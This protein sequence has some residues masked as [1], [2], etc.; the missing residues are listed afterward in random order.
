MKINK[1]RPALICLSMI[2][3]FSVCSPSIHAIDP[4]PE[5]GK[6]ISPIIENAHTTLPLRSVG[7][8]LDIPWNND[9]GHTQAVH[10]NK[11]YLT[12]SADPGSTLESPKLRLN[13]MTTVPLIELNEFKKMLPA[14]DFNSNFKI[15]QD[16]LRDLDTKRIPPKKSVDLREYQT[17]IK[18]QYRRGTCTSF[19]M[20]AAIEARYKHIDNKK[21]RN[22][23]LSEQ[24]ANYIQKVLHLAEYPSRLPPGPKY[25]ENQIGRWGSS[26]S[27]YMAALLA[28]QAALP[29]E[30]LMPYI[31]DESYGNTNED[32][33]NP[34]LDWN[35][36]WMEQKTVDDFNFTE[37][38]FPL[39]ALNGATYGISSFNIIPY[40]E[41]KNLD[42][43]KNILSNGYE[44]VF[45]F[46]VTA[47]DPS[48]NDD[49]WDPG[50]GNKIGVHS[51][52]IVGYDDAKN[53]FI[54]KNS[55]GYDNSNKDGFTLYSY[56]WITKGHVF[57][58]IYITDVIREPNKYTR[59]EQRFLGRWYLD[60][61]GWK[62]ILDIYHIPGFFQKHFPV[63][64]DFGPEDNRIGTYFAHDG[65][66]Y[67]VNGKIDGKT[68]EFY[69]DFEGDPTNTS[70]SKM[71][72]QP[73]YGRIFSWNPTLMAGSTL[74]DSRPYGFYASKTGYF[75]G[76][77]RGGAVEPSDFIG[78][79]G[80]NHD[81]WEGCLDIFDI[82]SNN[83][84][85]AR[86]IDRN[87]KILPVKG[88][89]VGN[90]ELKMDISFD[91]NSPQPFKALMFSWEK[92]VISGSTIWRGSPF[93]WVAYRIG[94][95]PDPV[96]LFPGTEDPSP[97]IDPKIPKLPKIPTA[98]KVIR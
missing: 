65:K 38:D 35:N 93:P 20:V 8:T 22:I 13:N 40:S 7:S 98:D 24:Y 86:Y 50:D 37:T 33:D 42:Y 84:I 29:E 64:S 58:A 90:R 15:P 2:T 28:H 6:D 57:D 47:P 10:P 66:V 79:W 67:R 18:N 69:I 95:P 63:S 60:H 70:Y 82:D 80:M 21:Y 46:S 48:P 27:M 44:I 55:W 75:S 39:S 72:G 3:A 83:N 77:G 1:I 34:K 53:C 30:K 56:D 23:D 68:I 16:L 87:G 32:R 25:R 49:I 31:G 54:V 41:L 43:Y 26:N 51:M 9:L 89:I 97:W 73:F 52:L 62:G 17:P 19:A 36:K 61:D 94:P 59:P 92:G 14:K 45:D 81:G 76:D 11:N 12:I 78:S 88:S 4:Q 5:Q 85:K 74:Y 71:V 96:K 91:S